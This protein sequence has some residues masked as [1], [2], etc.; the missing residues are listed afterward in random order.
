MKGDHNVQ[1][2]IFAIVCKQ[3][4]QKLI[5]SWNS[6][7]FI[8]KTGEIS[9][10]GALFSLHLAKDSGD[11]DLPPEFGNVLVLQSIRKEVYFVLSDEDREFVQDTIRPF[12][13]SYYPDVSR[14]FFTSSELRTLLRKLQGVTN[15]K[16][17]TDRVTT[18]SRALKTE[19]TQELIIPEKPSRRKEPKNAAVKYYYD[20]PFEKAFD[21]A[22]ANDEWIDKIQF[23]LEANGKIILDGFLSRAGL[24]KARR[25]FF[26]MYQTLFPY[27]LDII[28]GKFKLYSNRA[29]I[30]ERPKPSPLVLELEYDA[31]EDVKMNHKFIETLQQMPYVS[32][33]VYHGNPYIHLSLVDYLDGS[34]FEIWVLSANEITL[35][36]QLRASEASI[37]RLVNHI[38]ER[39]REGIV[40]EYEENQYGYR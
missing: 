27:L 21:E 24:I 28:Q 38:F 32:L 3:D 14:V 7:K 4:L 35:V 26:P 2:S 15:G 30:A 13:N 19:E 34:S 16:V 5:K 8:V 31:F 33:S 23:H 9:A 6:S 36:P 40:K 18:F 37:S 25:S 17:V 22:I 1:M 11:P 12:L 29:R 39:F 20:K 10:Q